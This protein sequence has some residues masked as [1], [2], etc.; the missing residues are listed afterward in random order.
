MRTVNIQSKI[1]PIHKERINPFVLILERYSPCVTS[2]DIMHLVF[3]TSVAS[4]HLRKSLCAVSEGSDV[5][6]SFP[7]YL[8][9]LRLQEFPLGFNPNHRNQILATQPYWLTLVVF[10]SVPLWLLNLSPESLQKIHINFTLIFSLLR[11][12]KYYIVNLFKRFFPSC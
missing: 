8:D 5:V 1:T 10:N 9:E 4:N 7:L 6:A 11:D 2:T 12:Y 3:N